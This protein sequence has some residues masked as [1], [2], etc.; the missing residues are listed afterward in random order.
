[1]INKKIDEEASNYEEDD[2]EMPLSE[3]TMLQ[4][5]TEE[6]VKENCELIKLVC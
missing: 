6:Q 5:V 4:P 1:M 2:F 3:K